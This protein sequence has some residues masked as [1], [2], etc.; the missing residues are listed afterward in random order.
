MTTGRSTASSNPVRVDTQFRGVLA[1]PAHRRLAICDALRRLR[2]VAASRAVLGANGDHAS[3]SQITAVGEELRRCAT[4][5]AAT[6][7]EHG[8]CTLVAGFPAL[9]QE[10]VQLERILLELLKDYF[11]VR[12]ELALLRDGGSTGENEQTGEGTQFH[13]IKCNGIMYERAEALP[14][15]APAQSTARWP[16]LARAP[17]TL[18]ARTLPAPFTS[19]SISSPQAPQR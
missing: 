11:L 18:T 8:G 5:P 15:K 19:R 16:M 13:R 14:F 17:I 2:T 1:H 3:R 9:G 7:K 10:Y 12:L 4:N 6:E